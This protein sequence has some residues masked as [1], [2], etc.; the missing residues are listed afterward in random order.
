MMLVNNITNKAGINKDESWNLFFWKQ[1]SKKIT[2]RIY[3]KETE[4]WLFEK[5]ND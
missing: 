1:A 5:K 3:R 4:V 2:T